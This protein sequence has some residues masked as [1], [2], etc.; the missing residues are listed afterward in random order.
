[1]HARLLLISIALATCLQSVSANSLFPEQTTV[2]EKS[3]HKLGEYRY[4]WRVFFNLYEA[5]LFVPEGKTGEDV[6]AAK[7]PFHLEFNYLREID[8]D[9]ILKSADQ[10]LD[11]NLSDSERTQIAERVAQINQVY[12][13][14][15]RGDRSSLTFLPGEGTTL[16]INREPKITIEGEDFAQLYFRIWLGPEAISASL[17]DNLLGRA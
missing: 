7:T 16:R 17:R 9:I 2:D 1:M 15:K 4:T 14:V 8:K 13:T 10:M 11:R 12:T 3:F 5:A 6:L